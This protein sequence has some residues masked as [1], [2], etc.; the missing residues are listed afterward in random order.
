MSL[1]LSGL[2]RPSPPFTLPLKILKSSAAL[3]LKL[4]RVILLLLGGRKLAPP[5]KQTDRERN[6]VKEKK[7][8]TQRDSGSRPGWTRRAGK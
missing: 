7:K 3:S 4:T 8:R 1:I 2:L 5:D 6:P